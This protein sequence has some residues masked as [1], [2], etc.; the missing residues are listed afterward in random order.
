MVVVDLFRDE[1]SPLHLLVVGIPNFSLGPWF[2]GTMCSHVL[3][4]QGID[5]NANVLAHQT[6]TQR[7]GKPANLERLA[8]HRSN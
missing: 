2:G 6:N 8:G 5:V 4:V 1:F 7:V 3:V